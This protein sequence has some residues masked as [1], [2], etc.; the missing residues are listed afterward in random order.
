MVEEINALQKN[1]T[2]EVVRLPQEKKTEGVSVLSEVKVRWDSGQVTLTGYRRLHTN[3]WDRLSEDIFS[4][5]QDEY[6]W[7]HTIYSN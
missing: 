1:Y 7:S 6:Y 2:W 3:L 5:G 4:S